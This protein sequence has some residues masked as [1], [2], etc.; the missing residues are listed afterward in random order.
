MTYTVGAITAPPAARRHALGS[1]AYADSQGY[2][3]CEITND[4]SNFFAYKGAS[5]YLTSDCVNFTLVHAFPYNITG[6]I[7]LPTGEVMVACQDGSSTPGYLYKSSGFSVSA[8]TAATFALKLTSIGGS[9]LLPYCLSRRSAGAD[10]RVIVSEGG[11]QTDSSGV[12]ANNTTKARRV[13][14]SK[15]FG[16]TW[17]VVWDIFN[18][19][20]ATPGGN[21]VHAVALGPGSELWITIGDNGHALTG[22]QMQI[23]RSNDNGATWQFLQQSDTPDYPF[24]QCVAIRVTAK[25]V[26]ML[27]DA[28]PYGPITIE[29]NVNGSLGGTM[30]AGPQFKPSGNSNVV[31]GQITQAPGTDGV[32]PWPIFAGAYV[33]IND[34]LSFE[35]IMASSDDG[36]SWY[37]IYTGY[38]L[39]VANLNIQGPLVS[40]LVAG[41][42]AYSN[43]GAW[44]S[45]AILK[46]NL[47]SPT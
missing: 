43:D 38:F 15:D 6:V 7:P 36:R 22:T 31:G 11:V 32:N 26:V 37:E 42:S 2:G 4:R 29:R 21:H 34:Q 46:A 12:D 3:L 23:V 10:G 8:P 1:V 30:H 45:G 17:A 25:R 35:K 24:L 28:P 14:L 27:P 40:G 18:N 9:F 33:Q 39:A 13:W 5:L 19:A 47:V 41:N 20:P 44:T 16:E